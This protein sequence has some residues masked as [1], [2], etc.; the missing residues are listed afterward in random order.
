M[1][2]QAN[3]VNI[4]DASHAS[5]FTILQEMS[6]AKRGKRRSSTR[7]DRSYRPTSRTPPPV[8]PR[9]TPLAIQQLEPVIEEV[10]EEIALTTTL[11]YEAQ[12]RKSKWF[13]YK[14]PNWIDNKT[15]EQ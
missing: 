9:S 1:P 2:G 6:D 5:L 3:Q 8:A 12:K 7:Y 14:N 13:G 10:L 15:E 11:M 4:F